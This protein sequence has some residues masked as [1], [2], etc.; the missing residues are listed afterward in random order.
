[1]PGRDSNQVINAVKCFQGGRRSV[2]RLALSGGM[3]V[4]SIL[5][6]VR[7]AAGKG[8]EGEGKPGQIA[9]FRVTQLTDYRFLVFLTASAAVRAHAGAT[10]LL[11]SAS[12]GVPSVGLISSCTF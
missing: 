5:N 2:G 6:Q 1:M 8:E 11:G 3:S 4:A 7:L 9:E 10:A 12:R